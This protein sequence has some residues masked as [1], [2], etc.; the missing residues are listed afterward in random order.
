M[1]GSRKAEL[2]PVEYFHVVFTVPEPIAPNRL[3][4]QRD[5]LQ[6]PFPRHRRNAAHHCRRPEAGSEPAL[7]SSPFCIPGDK[8]L[9]HH[10]HLHCVVPGGG[11]SLDRAS[12]DQPACRTSF[13]RSSAFKSVPAAI[14]RT[15]TSRLRREGLGFFGDLAYLAD[16]AAFAAHL[17]AVRRLDWIVYAKK[18][19][20]GPA[21]VLAY[22]GRYTHRVAISN[23]RIQTCDDEH[24]GF[25]WKDYRD[26]GAVKTMSLKPDEFIRRFLLHTF[27]TASIAF[28]T[29]DSS[30]MAIERKG[31]PS[32]A[33][34]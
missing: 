33:R 23:S 10:P 20:G 18:P 25:T 29:S 17:A 4:Q 21:Q 5:G 31:W 2:L 6:H 27:P 3:L 14:S 12:M 30:P 7:A 28:D 19:F 8:T 9:L 15:L 24:V 1:A 11:L 22:L 32:V 34:S 13:C 26:N 16:P